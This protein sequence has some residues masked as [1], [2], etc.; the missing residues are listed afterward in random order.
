[1]KIWVDADACP[2]AIKEIIYKAAE[3]LKIQ[4]V[5]VACHYMRVP[6]S[7]YI[8]FICVEKGMDAADLH[9]VQNLEQDHLVITADIPL[10]S[11]AVKKG[12]V[13][14]DPYGRLLDAQSVTEA[15]S[16][17][18]FLQSLRES[19]VIHSG[20]PRPFQETN[21]KQFA[22][23]FERQISLLQKKFKSKS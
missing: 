9:I 18:N 20:G 13:A 10:A 19:Q 15:L 7:Q 4:T 11:E 1:M 21:K 2:V 6:Q 5:F 12:A 22:A 3:R 23:Q 17:R 16:I 8:S 14:M